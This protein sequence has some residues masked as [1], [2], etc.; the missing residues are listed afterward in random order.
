MTTAL[1]PTQLPDQ[2]YIDLAVGI[3]G[4]AD[5]CQMYDLTT[6]AVEAIEETPQF[7]QR[8]KLA[9]QAV[10]DDGRAF[11]ARC[12][13]V[14]N[15]SIP[16]MEHMMLDPDTPSSTQ[17]E[18]FKALVRYG[19]LEPEKDQQIG[20][21]GPTF[22]LTIVAPDGSSGYAVNSTGVTIDH[23]ESRPALVHPADADGF[24]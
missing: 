16:H 18:A 9:Q 7:K 15:R 19:K 8:F 23:E 5:I 1:Q 4:F 6:E 17:L 14:V 20:P 13:T 22:S 11:R 10:E 12:R 3:H 24:F 21:V 2:F